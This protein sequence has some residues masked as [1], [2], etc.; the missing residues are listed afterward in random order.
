MSLFDRFRK[1]RKVT[2]EKGYEVYPAS[3][4][5][6]GWDEIHFKGKDLK[7]GGGPG[8][9]KSF[10]TKDAGLAREMRDYLGPEK[11][12][13]DVIVCEVDNPGAE[14]PRKS[15]IINAPWKRDE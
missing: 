6:T 3:K 14:S 5:A 10:Y 7:F 2:R 8:R 12:T 11:G 13:G 1:K 4:R 15:F 9:M